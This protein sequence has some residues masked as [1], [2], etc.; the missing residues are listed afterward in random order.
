VAVSAVTIK[1]L[2]TFGSGISNSKLV[3]KHSMSRLTANRSNYKTSNKGHSTVMSDINT[4][5]FTPSLQFGHEHATRRSRRAFASA[6]SSQFCAVHVAAATLGDINVTMLL[7][8]T[9]ANA[10]PSF[11]SLDATAPLF[12][13]SDHL[14]WLPAL[15]SAIHTTK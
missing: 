7:L 10:V 8:S 2:K 13:T 5:V 15:L 11:T 4:H 12:F 3:S 9:Y 6:S 1:P 14:G